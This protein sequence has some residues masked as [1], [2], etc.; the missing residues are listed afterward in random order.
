M[1]VPYRP[2]N[3]STVFSTWPA[4]LSGWLCSNGGNG[5]TSTGQPRRVAMS[6]RWAAIAPHATTAN[7]CAPNG[8]APN[9]S[10]REGELVDE[11]VVEVGSVRELDILHL[12][13]QRGRT[14]TF[15]LG[16][17]GHLGPLACHVA[18]AHDPQHGQLGYEADPDR[19][20]R[21]QVRTERAGQQHLG[22]VGLREAD[23]LEQQPPPGRDRRLG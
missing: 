16:Q 4:I 21:R 14:G 5:W 2:R 9:G 19:A 22:D 6:L 18:S 1:R 10:A 23:L 13:E 3:R 20:R 17:Q 11:A 15:G 7:G 8:S 12:L